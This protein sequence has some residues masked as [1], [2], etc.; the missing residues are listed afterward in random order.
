MG[1][2]GAAS[3]VQYGVGVGVVGVIY[4]ISNTP[5]KDG[6]VVAVSSDHIGEVSFSPFFKKI[7]RP[8]KSGSTYIP[9]LQPF[10]FRKL[11]FIIGFIHDQQAQFITEVVEVGCLRVMAGTNSVYA[12]FFQ[13]K[14]PAFP[15]FPGHGRAQNAGIVM[16][17]DA[18][19]FHRVTV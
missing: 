16:D 8:L 4:L 13:G 17:A 7:K 14:Q 1:K 11:P 10:S 9:A 15:Y 12:Y 3:A 5:G 6:K 2:A 19:H 18:L